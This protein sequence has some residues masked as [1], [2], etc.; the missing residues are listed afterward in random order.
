MQ[1]RSLL[2]SGDSDTLVRGPTR[3]MKSPKEEVSRP[4]HWMGIGGSRPA[5][6][7]RLKRSQ[8]AR[9]SVDLRRPRGVSR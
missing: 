2:G 9:T 8:E 7:C 3:L 5:K 6:Y 1:R 4:L